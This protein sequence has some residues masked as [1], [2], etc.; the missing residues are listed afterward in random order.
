VKIAV[1]TVNVGGYDS[2]EPI[3]YKDENV[4]YIYFTDQ[5]TAPEGWERR[6]IKQC[7][8]ADRIISRRIKALSHVYMSNY[9]ITVWIDACF[10]PKSSIMTL[11]KLLGDKDCLVLKHPAR[12]C[13]YTE[14]Q[15]CYEHG[16]SDPTRIVA[17]LNNYRDLG[18][19]KNNGLAATGILV[20]KNSGLI[21]EINEL[22]ANEITGK[23]HRDQLSFDFSFWVSNASYN[24]MD[25][26]DISKY[27]IHNKHKGSRL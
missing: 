9:D 7:G 25:F 21:K 12:E 23:A 16:I 6:A 22:W 13:I 2:P 3:K 20:R 24:S 15:F 27:F 14:G 18:Y 11:V 8:Y 19:P 5:K 26:Y 1:Y 10:V 4:D 17:Q